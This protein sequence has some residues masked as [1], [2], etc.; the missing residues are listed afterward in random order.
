MT[1]SLLL[2]AILTLC[3]LLVR[4]AG[5]EFTTAAGPHSVQVLDQTWSDAGRDRD[6]PV[7]L[8]VPDAPGPRPVVIF[9]HGLGGTREAA[10][11]LGQHWASH[12]YLSVHAQH[13]GSDDSAW[14]G[15]EEPLESLKAATRDIA[16]V[17][18]RPKDITFV[19]D[20]LIRRNAA[21][22]NGLA[23]QVDA[24]RIAVA[25][26]SFGAFTALAVSGQLLGAAR[27]DAPFD[28]TDPRVKA[29]IALS[30]PAKA[31]ES[32]TQ[33]I[34]AD[35]YVPTF[36]MTGTLDDSPIRETKAEDRRIPYDAICANESGTPQ[37]LVILEGGD[38]MVFSGRERSRREREGRAGGE[39]RFGARLR[40][41]LAGRNATAIQGQGGDPAKDAAFREVIEVGTLAF[42]E[43][44][45]NDDK[46]ANDYLT[47][48]SGYRADMGALAA[49]YE[50]CE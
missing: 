12:G 22:D 8:Y 31:R 33:K 19:I 41:R 46:G 26:H 18:D 5:A 40:E 49:S 43:A 39:G 15:R 1:R 2:A 9:S 3:L 28:F 13:P 10:A 16:V 48:P 35:Y 20:E 36:H 44:Y 50:F 24:E 47:S 37:Y 6:I 42:L 27:T 29:A 11:Y 17:T 32:G 23:G 25:G 21:P 4:S 30:A 14:R 34:Y 38:H 45:L 7:R